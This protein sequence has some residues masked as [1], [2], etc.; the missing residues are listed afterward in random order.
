M[1]LN[2]VIF[3]QILKFYKYKEGPYNTNNYH[4]IQNWPSKAPER[5]WYWK[6]WPFTQHL[7]NWL[8]ALLGVFDRG[9]A[10][11]SFPAKAILQNYTFT[12]TKSR[13]RESVHEPFTNNVHEHRSRKP[14]TSGS[15][16]FVHEHPFTNNSNTVQDGPSSRRWASYNRHVIRIFW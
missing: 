5:Y 14:F 13:I 3:T 16:T 4:I 10:Q 2:F 11:V 9:R 7:Q 12:N 8:L 6:K 15:R 1:L